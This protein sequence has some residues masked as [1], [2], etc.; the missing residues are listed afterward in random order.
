MKSEVYKV[1]VSFKKNDFVSNPNKKEIIKALPGT[2]KVKLDELNDMNNK[3]E[4]VFEFSSKQI[5]DNFAHR[6]FD[7]NSKILDIEKD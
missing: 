1:K 6:L 5:A 2:K 3:K 4:K 7:K